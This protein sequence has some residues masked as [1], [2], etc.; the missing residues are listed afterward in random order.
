MQG[1]VI[2]SRSFIFEA[3]DCTDLNAAEGLT[4]AA[5][6]TWEDRRGS[7]RRNRLQADLSSP[8]RRRPDGS[9]TEQRAGPSDHKAIRMAFCIPAAHIDIFDFNITNCQFLS[10]SLD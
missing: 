5:S 4:I 2:S 9:S 10:N 7:F 3:T 6:G 8:S 1:R